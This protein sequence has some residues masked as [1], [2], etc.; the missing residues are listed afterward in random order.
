MKTVIEGCQKC[1]AKHVLLVLD[2]CYSGY[3]ALKD[4]PQK[5]PRKVT[6]NYF[7]RI[8]S[9][10][11]LAAGQEDEP[12]SD[13][14]VRPGYS[15]FTGSLLDILEIERDLDGDGILTADEIWH[16]L[17]KQIIQREGV[18]QKPAYNRISGSEDGD[19]IFKLFDI[20]GVVA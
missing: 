16:N 3:A 17:E 8:A 12:V 18:N 14:G 11:A 9:R 7:S 19:F 20:D 1:I 10:R 4:V 13:S 2:C 5:R 15:A 6:E